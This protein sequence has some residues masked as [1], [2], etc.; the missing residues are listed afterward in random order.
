MADDHHTIEILVEAVDDVEE[1]IHGSGIQPVIH[2][3]PLGFV[4]DAFGD[5]RG[6]P[7]RP[8]CRT[9]QYQV[10]LYGAFGQSLTHPRCVTLAALVQRP[11]LVGQRGVIPTRFRVPHEKQGLHVAGVAAVSGTIGNVGG[12]KCNSPNFGRTMAI[13]AAQGLYLNCRMTAEGARGFGFTWN[14]GLVVIKAWLGSQRLFGR[15]YVLPEPVAAALQHVFGEPVGWVRIIEHSPYARIHLGMS[16]TTRPGRILLSISGAEFVA[17]PEFLL[18]EYFH[19]LRQWGRG[20]LTRWRYLTESARHGY[21]ANV[22]EREAREFAA[23]A[24]ERYRRYLRNLEL[25]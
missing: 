10:G 15:G 19:V 24:S 9:G 5:D 4:I 16:A 2:H 25:I 6:G 7:E 1:S 23:A 12:I 17:N 20:R 22:Y 18:H 3:N 21:W 14:G 8:M 13:I 11:F